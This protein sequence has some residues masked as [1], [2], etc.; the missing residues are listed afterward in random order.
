MLL[1]STLM[2]QL[3]SVNFDHTNLTEEGMRGLEG[4][5]LD[6]LEA[7]SIGIMGGIFS[8]EYHRGARVSPSVESENAQSQEI[9]F[10]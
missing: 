6:N 9:G 8:Q 5:Q 1:N 4:I 7:F 2:G 10:T 3:R